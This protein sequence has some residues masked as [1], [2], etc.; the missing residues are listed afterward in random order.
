ML[1]YSRF[2]HFYQQTYPQNL[3]IGRIIDQPAERPA[4]E[5]SVSFSDVVND[6]LKIFLTKVV[7]IRLTGTEGARTGPCR[8]SEAVSALLNPASLSTCRFLAAVLPWI[9]L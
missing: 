4:T 2:Y 1:A 6:R 7:H 5:G 8:G 3:W 9:A